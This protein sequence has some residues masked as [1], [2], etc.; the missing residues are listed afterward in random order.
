[1]DQPQ[2]STPRRASGIPRPTSRLPV[3]KQSASHSQLRSP[4]STEQLRKKPSLSSLARPAPA[5]PSLQKK[6]SRSSLAR[7]NTPSTPTSTLSSSNRTSL[8]PS[9]NRRVSSSALARPASNTDAP[10]F[11]KPIGR[12]ISYQPKPV[13]K[14][15]PPVS[16]SPEEDVLGSLDGFRSAS[17]ASSRGGGRD[18]D[19]ESAIDDDIDPPRALAPRKSRQS[20]SDRTIESLS[21]LPSSPAGGRVRRRSSFFGADNSMPPPL[22]PASRSTSRSASRPS[23]ALGRPVSS[24]GT[25]KPAPSTPRRLASYSQKGSMTAPG[26]RSVSA[27]TGTPS[28]STPSRVPSIARP[29]GT[30]KKQPL[31]QTQ[32]AQ[33]TP[34]PR[35]LTNTKMM[36]GRTPTS[37]PSA[38]GTFGQ[39]ISPPGTLTSTPTAAT[40]K[41]PDTSRKV[42]SSSAALREH[43][44]KAKASR[45]SDVAPKQSDAPPKQVGGSLALR[46]QIA[47]AKEAARRAH[48]EENNGNVGRSTPPRE[49][50]VPDPAEIAEFDFGLEDPFNQRSK[51]GKSLL[52]K[53][54]DAAR[55]DGR[56][57][58]AGMGLSE[59]PDDVLNMYKYDANDTTVAWGEVVDLTVIIA[60]DNELKSLPDQMFPDVDLDDVVDDDEAG[61]QFGGMQNI[62]LHGNVL[63][64]LPMGLRKLSQLSKLNLSRNSL[65]ID[66][67][68]VLS[69]IP[70]LRELRL[71]EN[72]LQDALPQSIGLLDQLEVLEL[73]GNKLT[74]LPEQVSELSRLRSLNVSDNQLKSVPMELFT[75]ISLVELVAAKNS[76]SG[77]FFTIDSAPNLQNLY[78]ANNGLA[79]LCESDTLSLPALKHLD[80]S[81]NRLSSLPNMTSWT[82]LTT[83]L[84][85]ENKISS[86]P[87]GFVTLQQLRTAD[88]TANDLTKLDDQIALME[89]LENLTVAANPI[90]ERKFLTMNTEDIKSDLLSR[91]APVATDDDPTD[92]VNEADSEA[93]SVWKL[94][95]SG[96]LDLSFQNLTEVDDKAMQAFV[97]TRE[98]R[99]LYLQQNYLTTIP[100][101]LADFSHLTMLDLSKNSI[102][103]LLTKSLN[104]PKVRELRLN[105]N[106]LQSFDE[107]TTFISAPNLQQLNVSNNRI[108]GSLPIMRATFPQLFTLI[109]SDNAITEVSAESLEGLKVANLSNNNIARL[110]P[111]IGLHL[112]TLTSLDVEGNTF[113][114]P[115]YAVLRKGTEAVLNWLKDK[116][117]SPTEEFFSADSFGSPESARS[118]RST[119][120]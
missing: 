36:N 84:V 6:A 85:G 14:P 83:L 105:G 55:V 65:T 80:L 76:F 107:I 28:A 18:Q 92:E 97:E 15:S 81:T 120:S 43:I 116:I 38:G 13:A 101:V 70:T 16:S 98:V 39:A 72:D 35:P 82:S 54:V 69:Q 42:S 68:D 111:R 11:K 53:R 104:M 66:V 52:R 78:L 100:L 95:P 8:G 3:L 51:G 115:N 102:E 96:T 89:S 12:P 91:M 31:S 56:L 34:K 90:R 30:V 47:K 103:V 117:P 22:H 44:A 19:S 108:A 88:F 26:K 33:T 110:E 113:R 48:A 10:A 74:S 4:S 25:P 75:S 24:D 106:K 64:T 118:A 57:N 41:T 5:S 29:T 21:Q 46:E 99:Q 77:P 73:Q 17:R 114:V 87:E 49:P 63:T 67:F 60:A 9:L 1:M 109:A 59:V 58:L 27:T 62:D 40:K 79:S 71:A 2:S 86:L 45:R 61:P 93:N 7:S 112:G 119:M 37:R 50:I 20:L 94:T 32:N 23:S